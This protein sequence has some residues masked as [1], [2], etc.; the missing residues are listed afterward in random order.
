MLL[1]YKYIIKLILVTI[2]ITI[3][4]FTVYAQQVY[5]GKIIDNENNPISYVTI[6]QQD[7][8]SNKLIVALMSDS[9]GRFEITTNNSRSYLYFS[10][11]GYKSQK[12]PMYLAKSEIV[13]RLEPDQLKLNEVVIKAYKRSIQFKNDR[14]VY[15]MATNPMKNDNFLEALKF[16]P[17][18]AANGEGFSII[19]KERTDFYINGRKSNLSYDALISFLKSLP[20]DNVKNI[21]V[22]TAPNSTYRGDGN[23][24]IINIVLKKNE[25]EG[26]NGT[27]SGQLWKTHYFKERGALNLN[28]SK[29]KLTSSFSAGLTNSSDW[30]ENVTETQYKKNG[31]NTAS[32]S[33]TDGSGHGYFG[34]LTTDYHLNK[35]EIIGFILNVSA[36][37]GAWSETGNTRYG[38]ILTGK[39]DSLIDM[40]YISI[41]TIHDVG[42]NANYR[43]YC[44]KFLKSIFVDVDYLINNSRPAYKNIMNHLT[45]SGTFD[46]PY[47]NIEQLTIQKTNI[48]SGKI[49]LDFNVPLLTEFKAGLDSYYSNIGNDDQYNYWNNNEYVIDSLQ[50]NYFKITEWTSAGFLY[51]EKKWNSKL[52][53]SVGSRLEYT[54]YKGMQFTTN[55]SFTN[56]YL[57]WLPELYVNYNPAENHN[58]I[59]Q[60]SYRMTRPSFNA[61]N[62]FKTYISP[63]T[64]STGNPFLHPSENISQNLGYSFLGQYNF[65]AS[66]NL[67]NNLIQS[68]RLVKDDYL[69]EAKPINIGRLQEFKLSVNINKSY[70]KGNEHI[71][72]SLSYNWRYY[73]G[74][75]EGLELDYTNKYLNVELNNYFKLSP[76]RNLSLDFGG[77]FYSKQIYSN[78]ETP[79]SLNLNVQLR[80]GYKNMQL[81]LYSNLGFYFY[82]NTWTQTQRLIYETNVL[83]SVT[84]K[85]GEP[86][87]FGIRFAYNFGNNKVKGL[88]QHET[89]NSEARKRIQ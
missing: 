30:K 2:N 45:E 83:Q 61:L 58:F 5:K 82:E 66:Y 35:N 53:T 28:Y 81:S 69:I 74:H 76:K 1:S 20:A 59:Y 14:I 27:I 65:N 46:S 86:T 11:I 87:S 63:T 52:F 51:A 89:S 70:L 75:G 73:K 42:L 16:V 47:K 19:G 57:K 6:A 37:K 15:D 36:N 41:A 49:E 60:L 32:N 8:T 54:D 55:Y 44:N 7:S 62:P 64:Y 26:L 80:K 13:I 21:E 40:K 72:L 77:Y 78:T 31:L 34:N 39:V 88:E 29:S 12:M 24:G 85:K 84:F 71:N 4:T 68:T 56:R 79:P 18:V 9:I 50:S 3:S 33:I 48:W 38:K 25:A 10:S 43:R 23:F 17:F 22:I 67:I